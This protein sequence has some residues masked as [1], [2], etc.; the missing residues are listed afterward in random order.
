MSFLS[1]RVALPTPP[2]ANISGGD[3]GALDVTRESPQSSA[4]AYIP[5]IE[6]AFG[7][8]SEDLSIGRAIA[9]SFE[10]SIPC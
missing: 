6:L 10:G 2:N 4:I 1:W 8:P 7:C 9:C 5:R 3:T